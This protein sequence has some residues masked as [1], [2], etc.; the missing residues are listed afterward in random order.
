MSAA[1]G[2]GERGRKRVEWRLEAF[3][4][5]IP[6]QTPCEVE[7][8]DEKDVDQ[9]GGLPCAPHTLAKRIYQEARKHDPECGVEQPATGFG[10]GVM[11]RKRITECQLQQR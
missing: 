1:A 4:V 5:P 8:H 11:L 7:E 10:G 2:S 6:T 9:A 3:G